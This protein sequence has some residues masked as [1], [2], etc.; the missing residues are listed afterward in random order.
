MIHESVDFRQVISFQVFIAFCGTI[1][2][3]KVFMT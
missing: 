3:I 1:V 2:V